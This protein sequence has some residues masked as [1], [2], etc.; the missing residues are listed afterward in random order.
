MI[1]MD[2]AHDIHDSVITLYWEIKLLIVKTHQ[3][4]KQDIDYVPLHAIAWAR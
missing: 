1:Y 4:T 2:F 3:V